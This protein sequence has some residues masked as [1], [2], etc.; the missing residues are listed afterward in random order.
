MIAAHLIEDDTVYETSLPASVY[1]T[2]KVPEPRDHG[3]QSSC[4][5]WAT[6]YA[7]RS[8]QQERS[9]GWGLD[10]DEHLFSPAYVYNQVCGS[11]DNGSSISRVLDL[12]TEQGVC[13]LAFFPYDAGDFL[14]QPNE[15]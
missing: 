13:M 3:N 4:T 1:L 11:I 7:L 14:T 9:V 6:A 8:Y 15:E 5:A 2:D 12:M 10:M